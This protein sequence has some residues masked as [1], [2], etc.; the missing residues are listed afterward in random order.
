MSDQLI[1]THR[2]VPFLILK[3]NTLASQG[4]FYMHGQLCNSQ[5]IS[6][7]YS[8]NPSSN[9]KSLTSQTTV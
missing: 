4:V 1:T 8:S 6:I 5:T 3:T 7:V 9:R 2:S